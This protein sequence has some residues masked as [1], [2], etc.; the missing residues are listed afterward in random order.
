MRLDDRHDSDKFAR[1]QKESA[2]V[3]SLQPSSLLRSCMFRLGASDSQTA[4]G[5]PCPI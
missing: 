5:R 1:A 4:A 2:L 3:D